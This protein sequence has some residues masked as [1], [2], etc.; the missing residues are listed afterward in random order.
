MVDFLII[1]RSARAIA[2]SAKRAGYKVNVAD[3]FN[4]EDTKSFSESVYQLQFHDDDFETEELIK[5]IQEVISLYPKIKLV[6]GSGFESNPEQLNTLSGIAP[7]LANNKEL[8]IAL[9]DP[10]KFFGMLGKYSILYPDYSLSRPINLKKYLKKSIGGTGGVHVN[11]CDQT[12][13]ENEVDC[14]FQEYIS[15]K[16]LSAVFLANGT[17]S[18]IVGFN[19][20]LQSK[21]FTEM[22]FLYQGA[23]SLRLDTVENKEIIEDIINKITAETGLKGLCGLDYIVNEGGEVVV[24]EVNPRPPASFELHEMQQPLF[25]AHL[26]CFDGKLIDLASQSECTQSLRGYAILYAKEN[27][28]I[29]DKVK[30]PNW[31]KDKP[32]FDSVIPAGFPICTVHAE[33]FSLDKVKSMLFNRLDKIETIIFAEQNA[34]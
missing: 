20:Q 7:V 24:L 12:N 9:K 8:I 22:P 4:D 32:K 30:W 13:S 23:I 27:M 5:H 11:W 10:V 2:A 25:D 29:S 33:A 6:I 26:A 14:Y 34:A 18:N 16:V 21:D 31:V 17:C 1:A 3:C 15:G 28:L 19:Q